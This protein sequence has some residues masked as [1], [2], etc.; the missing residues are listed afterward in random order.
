MSLRAGFSALI[1]FLLAWTAVPAQ[2]Q[3]GYY[4][5]PRRVVYYAPRPVYYSPAPVVVAPLAPV[6]VA[7]APVVVVRRRPAFYRP[8][9]VVVVRGGRRW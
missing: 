8:R 3:Y 4:R 7:P 1:L 5:Q 2:A 9:P 6:V